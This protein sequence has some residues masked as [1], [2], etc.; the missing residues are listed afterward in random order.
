MK[1][2]LYYYPVDP[3]EAKGYK[4]WYSVVNMFLGV[5]VWGEGK[6]EA[7][8]PSSFHQLCEQFNYGEI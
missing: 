4:V 3:I 2:V 5:C 1:Q 6:G 8:S 7:P